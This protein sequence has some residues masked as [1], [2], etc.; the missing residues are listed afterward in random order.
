MDKTAHDYWRCARQ[1]AH[2]LIEKDFSPLKTFSNYKRSHV[3]KALAALSK[4]LGLYKEFRDLR[5]AY[6]IKWS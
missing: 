6:G 4:F 3:L 1:Y 2:L 5:E